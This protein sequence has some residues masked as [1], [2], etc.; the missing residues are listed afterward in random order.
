MSIVSDVTTVAT[1]GLSTVYKWLAIGGVLLALCVG[2]YFYGHHVGAMSGQVALADYQA[3][4][5]QEVTE[6]LGVNQATADR[7]VLQTQTQVKT[8]YVHDK[9]IQEQIPSLTDTEHLS[10]GWVRLYNNSLSP[11]GSVSSPTGGTDDAVEAI[12]A[13]DA[14]KGITDNNTTCLTYKARVDAIVQFE[15]EQQDN[16]AKANKAVK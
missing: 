4:H 1:G 2:C 3:K 14:L 15:N 13:I 9:A 6:L 10:F 7:I 11:S 16:I 5:D 12:G 8:I